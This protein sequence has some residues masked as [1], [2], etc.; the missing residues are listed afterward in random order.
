MLMM[1]ATRFIDEQFMSLVCFVKL[2]YYFF[3]EYSSGIKYCGGG[4]LIFTLK[5]LTQF[6][7]SVSLRLHV[8]PVSRFSSRRGASKRQEVL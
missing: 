7:E 8:D 5:K 4:N 1:F 6:F 3:E 2:L